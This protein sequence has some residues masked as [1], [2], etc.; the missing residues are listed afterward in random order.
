MTGGNR[1]LIDDGDMP[2]ARPQFIHLPE[3]EMWQAIAGGEGGQAPPVF[4][5]FDAKAPASLRRKPSAFEAR[6]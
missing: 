2:R 1:T 4:P 3:A 5:A 6:A